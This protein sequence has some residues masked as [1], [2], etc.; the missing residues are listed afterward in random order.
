MTPPATKGEK[1]S[2]SGAN[3]V[4]RVSIS[5]A[6]DAASYGATASVEPIPTSNVKL[7]VHEQK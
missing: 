7:A 5:A 6:A 2:A 4:I 3:V 1:S